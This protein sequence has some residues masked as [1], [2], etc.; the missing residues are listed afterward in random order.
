MWIGGGIYEYPNTHKGDKRHAFTMD[1]DGS[2]PIHAIWHSHPTGPPW[3]SDEDEAVMRM[4][5]EMGYHW[6]HIIA[7][8]GQ[9]IYEYSVVGDDVTCA[10]A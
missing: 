8:P 7:V 10:Q 9:G 1:I 3:P 5:Y 6:Q 2:L 4:C